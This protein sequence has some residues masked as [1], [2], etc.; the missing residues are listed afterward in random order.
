MGGPIS[1]PALE[2]QH[3]IARAVTFESFIGHRRARDVT[4]QAFELFALMGDAAHVGMQAK[5]VFG[6]TTL[7]GH[8][9]FLRGD[10]FQAQDL[11]ACPGSEGNPVGTSRRLQGRQGEIG[12][13]FG[14]VGD[15]LL[16][17]EV[18]STC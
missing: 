2:L 7:G 17:N 15:T 18:A 9:G 11:L 14:Q 10:G 4:A 5:A 3:D 16:F 13:D 8:L 6:D 1:V 12:I